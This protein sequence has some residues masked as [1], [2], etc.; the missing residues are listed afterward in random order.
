MHG[1][2]GRKIGK[3]KK[4][5]KRKFIPNFYNLLYYEV[6]SR[7]LSRED[8]KEEGK[9]LQIFKFCNITRAKS[10]NRMVIVRG[11]RM[12]GVIEKEC[13]QQIPQIGVQFYEDLVCLFCQNINFGEHLLVC[14]L[15]CL[16]LFFVDLYI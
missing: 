5:Q 7:Q 15:R 8:F 9:N 16:Y 3:G 12:N 13:Y 11:G 6:Y 4:I 1:T 2:Y 10:S 14:N